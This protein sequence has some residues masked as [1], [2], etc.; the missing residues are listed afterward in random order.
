[1]PGDGL[2]QRVPGSGLMNKRAEMKSGQADRVV[3]KVD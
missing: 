1:M 2:V 3:E